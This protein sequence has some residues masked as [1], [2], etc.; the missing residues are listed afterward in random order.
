MGRIVITIIMT[1][2]WRQPRFDMLKRSKAVTIP[3]HVEVARSIRNAMARVVK[4]A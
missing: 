1:N 3:V 4:L 2:L